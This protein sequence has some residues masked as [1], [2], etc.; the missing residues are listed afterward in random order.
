VQNENF[1][2]TLTEPKNN[3]NQKKEKETDDARKKRRMWG[4]KRTEWIWK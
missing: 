1:N 4:A 3:T 2:V